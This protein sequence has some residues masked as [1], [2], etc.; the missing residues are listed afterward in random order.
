MI[1]PFTRETRTGIIDG[2]VVGPEDAPQFLMLH[3]SG[4]G[5]ASLIRLAESAAERGHCVILPNLDGYGATRVEGPDAM[6]RHMAVARHFLEQ[7]SPPLPVFGHSMGGFVTLRLA[8]E[9]VAMK[10]ISVFEPV[11]IGVLR[12]HAEDAEV[13]EL[14]TRAVSRIAPLMAQG[15]AED[16]VR[17][18]ISLWNGDRWDDLP[19]KARQ[20]IVAMAPQINAD[21]AKVSFDTH[22]AS[23]YASIDA[24]VTLIGSENGP[25]PAGRILDRLAIALPRAMRVTIEGAGHMGP[26]QAPEKFAAVLPLD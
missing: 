19:E 25:P 26:L 23:H 4:T 9:G 15:R 18:F 13:L 14:D 17:D 6:T 22:F 11:A 3:A 21:T 5:S 2:F 7:S 1:R 20:S 10:R 8:A 12:E 24:P 16:A